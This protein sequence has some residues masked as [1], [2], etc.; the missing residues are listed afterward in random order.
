MFNMVRTTKETTLYQQVSPLIFISQSRPWRVE[1]TFHLGMDKLEYYDL[2]DPQIILSHPSAKLYY[3]EGESVVLK[4]TLAGNI[5]FK[6]VR[7]MMFREKRSQFVSLRTDYNKDH[8]SVDAMPHISEHQT[9]S[10]TD[11]GDVIVNV[12]IHINTTTEQDKKYGTSIITLTTSTAFGGTISHSSILQNRKT[13]LFLTEGSIQLM[14]RECH[15]Q[16]SW[17]AEVSGLLVNQSECF[18]C[19]VIAE[20]LTTME[21]LKDGQVLKTN[22]DHSI[23]SMPDVDIFQ[24]PGPS[25]GYVIHSAAPGGCWPV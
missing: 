18:I 14:K 5:T 2:V 1:E 3:D 17:N 9:L 19:G 8:L 11:S 22:K 24:I 21:M 6:I 10:V 4:W 23:V 12:Q 20:D 13:G 25:V 15:D 16:R 7:H